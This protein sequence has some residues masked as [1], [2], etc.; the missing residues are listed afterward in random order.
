MGTG[1]LCEGPDLGL[2]L[3][4]R[5]VSPVVD[6][7]SVRTGQVR[8]A[9]DGIGIQPVGYRVDPWALV[10]KG[11]LDVGTAGRKAL[12]LARQRQLVDG[13]RFLVA[14][15][16]RIRALSG[17]LVGNG[18]VERL[19]GRAVLELGSGISRGGL[20]VGPNRLVELLSG[21]V[22]HRN[23]LDIPRDQTGPVV[24][25][26][27]G[28]GQEES[29][30]LIGWRAVRLVHRSAPPDRDGAPMRIG[31]LPRERAREALQRIDADGDRVLSG[32]QPFVDT[33]SAD[34]LAYVDLLGL[35]ALDRAGPVV[36][37]AVDLSP[38]VLI[39]RPAGPVRVL[40]DVVRDRL[41]GRLEIRVVE[42]ERLHRAGLEVHDAD[43]DVLVVGT[44][45]NV[46]GVFDLQ[47]DLT[48]RVVILPVPVERRRTGLGNLRRLD[49]VG[50][51]GLGFGLLRLGSRVGLD[52]LGFG[53]LRLGSRVGLDDLHRLSRWRVVGK[54][55]AHRP[56]AGEAEKG[57]GREN[58]QPLPERQLHASPPSS[59]LWVE[60]RPCRYFR[61]G[62][63][64][65]L[66]RF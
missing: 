7:R 60:F 3:V 39:P 57:G 38:L 25:L 63:S 31:K 52:G 34:V 40:G 53:L 11:H 21:G 29:R 61:P 66:V 41:A 36:V 5:V 32:L 9:D 18:V 37:R 46:P 48:G 30:R 45:R 58:G 2:G 12:A 14:R 10:P 26:D 8:A 27:V 13:R 49:L 33:R 65:S 22:D 51:G 64:A 59:T 15:F 62:K 42:V 54:R 28:L 47:A 6:D 35:S 23:P 24:H 16:V 43:I 19:D 44:I 17:Q 1:V 56:E 50:L 20:G 4:V 55:V